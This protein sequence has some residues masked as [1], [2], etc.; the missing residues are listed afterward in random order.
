MDA[1]E[2]VTFDVNWDQPLVTDTVFSGTVTV[3]ERIRFPVRVG[4]A[5]AM[6]VVNGPLAYVPVSGTKPGT[7]EEVDNRK[8]GK[9]FTLDAYVSKA[10]RYPTMYN[11]STSVHFLRA[12]R[13]GHVTLGQIIQATDTHCS[14]VD[15]AAFYRM[16]PILNRQ[17][18]A[19]LA[20]D[21]MSQAGN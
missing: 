18:I 20:T 7:T 21:Y 11:A 8:A 6:V 3:N 10:I 9:V 14:K 4:I 12:I 2:I 1:S 15:A 19:E 16:R 13:G 5:R 17:D